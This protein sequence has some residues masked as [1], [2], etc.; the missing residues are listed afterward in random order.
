MQECLQRHNLGVLTAASETINGP[1]EFYFSPPLVEDAPVGYLRAP[2]LQDALL[3]LFG[4]RT[5]RGEVSSLRRDGGRNFIG[6]L[7]F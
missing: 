3:L 5:M 1:P 2:N 4:F 6:C 7:V